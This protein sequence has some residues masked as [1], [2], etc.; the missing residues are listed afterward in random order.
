[1]QKHYTATASTTSILD[2]PAFSWSNYPSRFVHSFT[3]STIITD[4]FSGH[5]IGFEKSYAVGVSVSVGA[6]LGL[7][8]KAASAGISASV[9]F[10]T[11]T[12]NTETPSWT[13]PEGGAW[14][15][16]LQFSPV[17]IRIDGIVS[18]DEQGDCSLYSGPT[19]THP[20]TIDYPRT[21]A[22]NLA[23]AEISG[24]TCQNKPSWADPGHYATLCAGEC[25]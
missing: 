12:S 13:C 19:G 9:T 15:C 10:S 18:F 20:Y 8:V 5:T 22:A 16:A 2:G 17:Y 21:D 25:A 24:C 11:E 4:C 7:D 6:D 14:M 3:A 23:M 1:M